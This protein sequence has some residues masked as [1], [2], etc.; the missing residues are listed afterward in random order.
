[1]NERYFVKSM[2][3]L[4]LS[5]QGNPRYKFIV[6]DRNG[7]TK[8][9]HTSPNA[10]WVYAITYGWENRMIQAVTHETSRNTIIDAAELAETF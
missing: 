7:D 10:V 4:K 2:S 5:P 6:A 1:M 3:R 9:L 8:I